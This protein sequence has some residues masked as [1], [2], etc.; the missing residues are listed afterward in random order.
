M[1][2]IGASE[3]DSLAHSPFA[4]QKADRIIKAA[5]NWEYWPDDQELEREHEF[6]DF[7]VV[8]R[9]VLENAMETIKTLSENY[10][11]LR[12]QMEQR[13]AVAWSGRRVGCRQSA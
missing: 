6:L 12:Q 2:L 10:N 7:R 4:K 5:A 3:L 8:P 11:K 13:H 1:G 9:R